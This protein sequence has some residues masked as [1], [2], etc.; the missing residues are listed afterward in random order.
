MSDTTSQTVSLTL[1]QRQQ[2]AT[3]VDRMLEQA[4]A[5][6]L[7]PVLIGLLAMRLEAA[8]EAPETTIDL[9]LFVGRELQ[10]A[11]Q[12]IHDATEES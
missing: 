11:L 3:E 5:R 8:K 2:F 6:E 4:R 12:R 1:A 7:D 9:M 10:Q